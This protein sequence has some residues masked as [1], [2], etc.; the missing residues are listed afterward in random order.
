MPI[1]LNKRR[2]KKWRSLKPKPRKKVCFFLFFFFLYCLLT[3]TPEGKKLT[4]EQQRAKDDRT[5][6]FGNYPSSMETKK[7]KAFLKTTFGEVRK[8]KKKEGERERERRRITITS[9]NNR[10]TPFVSVQLVPET[11][12]LLSRLLLSP[13][14]SIPFA[15]LATPT[16]FSRFFPPLP[17]HFFFFLL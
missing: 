6:F 17:F 5:V 9:N 2:Q 15:N 10:L 16:L 8:K 11:P 3:P 1:K 13:A 12:N 14:L 4:K 7:F